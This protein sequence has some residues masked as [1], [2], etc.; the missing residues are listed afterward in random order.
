MSKSKWVV[1]FEE[2]DTYMYW[3]DFESKKEAKQ[4]AKRMLKEYDTDKEYSNT[5][6]CVRCLMAKVTKVYRDDVYTEEE[7]IEGSL[8]H[9]WK[10]V[11]RYV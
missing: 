11:E 7:S 2:D 5:L 6:D 8:D 10:D 9:F 3:Q 4:G 1:L